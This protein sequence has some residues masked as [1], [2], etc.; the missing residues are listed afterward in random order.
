[1][2]PG[3]RGRPRKRYKPT[4]RNA[5]S[6]KL[7]SLFDPESPKPK[8]SSEHFVDMEQTPEEAEI[9]AY[10]YQRSLPPFNR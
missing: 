4:G 9:G 3:Q 5:A 2:P 6:L 8:V 10:N 7:L 1:M